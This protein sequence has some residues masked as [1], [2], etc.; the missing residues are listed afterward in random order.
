MAVR[1]CARVEAR[2]ACHAAR[3]LSYKVRQSRGDRPECR[4][5]CLCRAG[6]RSCAPSGLW[7]DLVVDL[8][9]EESLVSGSIADGEFRTSMIAGLGGGSYEM[10]LNLIS[11]LWLNLPKGA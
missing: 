5:G 3:L 7:A 6:P 9:A 2:A 11:R 8:L 4:A 1:R 10:Q